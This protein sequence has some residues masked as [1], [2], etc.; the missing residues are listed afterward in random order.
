[1]KFFSY[2]NHLLSKLRRENLA[3]DRCR[4]TG[5]TLNTSMD[6]SFYG[7]GMDTVTVSPK[8]QVV[9]PQEVRESAGIRPGDRMV[10]LQ[11]GD[12]IYLVRVRDIKSMRGFAKGVSS[13]GMRDESERFG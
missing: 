1:V 3:I 11:K 8:F 4:E 12:V 5:K 6:K 2:L 10:V 9:I 13:K 7:I